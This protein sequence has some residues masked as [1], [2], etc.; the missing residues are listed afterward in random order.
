VDQICKK[1]AKAFGDAVSTLDR[2]GKYGSDALR[3]T[4]ARGANPG[5]D[6]PI[7]EDWVQGSRNFANKI[8]NATRFALMNGATV[9]GPL[10]DASA[11]S[12]TDRW[13]LSR[14]NTV[15]AEVDAYYEDFQLDRKS[16]RLNS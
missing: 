10:P 7:G 8:W 9:E 2:M 5:V 11:M 14:L 15:V 12:P 6:V 4:L 13:I 16:T 1:L 3:F